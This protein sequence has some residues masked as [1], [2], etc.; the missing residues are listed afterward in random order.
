M[1]RE[2]AVSAVHVDADQDHPLNALKQTLVVADVESY[3]STQLYEKDN[4][5]RMTEP[6]LSSRSAANRT[7]VYGD[8]DQLGGWP[9]CLR[10]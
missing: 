2:D 4:L 8:G 6:R 1:E 7:V 5:L 10:D 9:V 3:D